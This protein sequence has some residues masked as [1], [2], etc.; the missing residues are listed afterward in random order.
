MRKW[1]KLGSCSEG[2]EATHLMRSRLPCRDLTQSV[3]L[4]YIAV[5]VPIRIGFDVN[6]GVG[7]F[8][9][10][11][12]LCVDIY[13][14]VDIVLNFRTGTYNK[15]GLVICD[16]KQIR[17]SYLTGWFAVD[18]VSC[19]P[20]SYIS[21]VI[22]SSSG[23]LGS[24][25]GV[26]MLRLLRLAK[27]LR[28]GRLKRIMERY[29]EE[30]QPYIKMV[31]LI[32]MLLVAAFLAHLLASFW[33]FVGQDSY[34][35]HDGSLVTGWV[36]DYWSLPRSV[37]C[38]IGDAEDPVV[39]LPWAAASVEV[40]LGGTGSEGELTWDVAYLVSYY[41]AVTTLTTIG[42][43]DITPHT[44]EEMAFSIVGEALGGFL[45]GM[46]VGSL[47]SHITAGNIAE[48]EYNQEMERVREFLR[49]REVPLKFR[50]KVMAFYV[51][52]FR[53]KTIFKEEDLLDKLPD[54]MRMDL[55]KVMYDKIIGPVPFF[56]GL[57]DEVIAEVCQLTKPLTFPPGDVIIREG[58]PPQHFTTAPSGS[59]A[60]T[61]P[62]Q[63]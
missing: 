10:S 62:R 29:S 50:R 48:Q 7:T 14:W 38:T 47:S 11:L 6:N 35:K 22:S 42:Y 43:G 15:D 61:L 4:I 57:A 28:L 52:L 37:N 54:R 19:F 33:F 36:E 39:C 44:K 16:F 45:F 5:V 32:G 24:A 25:K 59:S 41:W 60:T 56:G 34:I 23:Q 9:W 8:A 1:R 3:L 49:M 51:N 31:K 40:G 18:L 30:L 58:V 27:M 46:L 21:L 20:A 12:E 26:R 55:M 2:F 63:L 17:R 53:S 13:F